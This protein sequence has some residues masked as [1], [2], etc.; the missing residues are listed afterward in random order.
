MLPIIFI[1]WNY[2]ATEINITNCI[3]QKKKHIVD[4]NKPIREINHLMYLTTVIFLSHTDKKC[5]Q[6]QKTPFSLLHVWVTAL[7]QSLLCFHDH[8]VSK[9]AWESIAPR[10]P[11]RT[12]PP[13]PS[14][15]EGKTLLSL[16]SAPLVLLISAE[17]L[18]K[19]IFKYSISIYLVCLSLW[20]KEFFFSEC[21]RCGSDIYSLKTVVHAIPQDSFDCCTE[22]TFLLSIISSFFFYF[23]HYLWFSNMTT[24]ITN[25]SLRGAYAC[26]K[27]NLATVNTGFH[28]TVHGAS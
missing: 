4:N 21:H 17:N 8:P 6:E 27:R 16:P 26:E 2:K 23:N 11:D 7:T 3:M 25:G 5:L 28:W 19:P 9:W 14:C 15:L 13:L 20:W 1:T 22:W 12:F 24:R 10:F 18:S